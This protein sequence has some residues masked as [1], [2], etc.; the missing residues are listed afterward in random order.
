[1]IIFSALEEDYKQSFSLVTSQKGKPQLSYAGYIYVEEKKTPNKVY[2]RCKH[3]TSY[4]KCP[5]RLHTQVNKTTDSTEIIIKHA[6]NHETG[7]VLKRRVH[8]REVFKIE[9]PLTNAVELMEI[10]I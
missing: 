4:N 5:G 6:H 9:D 3:Y 8:R 1:M 7:F 2:W 10:I